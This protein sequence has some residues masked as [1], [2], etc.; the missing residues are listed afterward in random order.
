MRLIYPTIV[1]VSSWS[2]KKTLGTSAGHAVVPK[3]R[4]PR[5]APR[6]PPLHIAL[7]H[8]P[9][10]DAYHRS[11]DRERR[12]TSS[13]RFSLRFLQVTPPSTLHV[14]RRYSPTP[15]AGVENQPLRFR[16]VRTLAHMQGRI[17][18]PPEV[19]RLGHFDAALTGRHWLR[20]PPEGG[21]GP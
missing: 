7:R 16:R 14:A 21:F 8:W 6:S 18:G 11:D 4:E 19:S 5:S 10:N 13:V 17:V 15:R 2:P 1:G 9:Y 3:E 20:T 12:G